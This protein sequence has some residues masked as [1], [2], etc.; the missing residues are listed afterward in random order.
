MAEIGI[1]SK[2]TIVAALLSILFCGVQEGRSQESPHGKIRFECSTCHTT[3][4][5]KISKSSF[6]HEVTGFELTGRH[7]MLRCESCH[8][9]LKFAKQSSN[10]LSCHTDIHKS[11]LGTNCL[12]CHTTKTWNITDM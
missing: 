3:D 4:T 7:A 10:C 12:R 1:L 6:K 2:R 5:W 11:E 9:G 8:E